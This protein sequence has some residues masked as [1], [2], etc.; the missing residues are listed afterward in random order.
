[1][2]RGEVADAVELAERT[3]ANVA[4]EEGL[5][6]A[7]ALERIVERPDRALALA[8][9][10]EKAGAPAGRVA[11]LKAEALVAKKDRAGAV[12]LLIGVGAQAP[13]HV[14]ARLRA[15][16]LLREDGKLAECER[17]LDDTVASAG[18]P[19]K[20][21]GHAQAIVIARTL[22]DE[23]RGD[24]VRAV[25]RL[26]EALTHDP[27]DARLLLARSAIDERRGEWRRAL[28]TAE[29]L[30][31]REPRNVEALNFA[32]FVAADHGND[33]PLA[34]RRL[35]ASVVLSPGSGGIIDSLG[36]V[37]FRAGD[38]ERAAAFLEQ[39]NRLEPGDAEI[40]SHLG[41]LYA[42]RGERTRA[43][44]AYRRALGLKPSDKLARELGDRVRTLDAK[45]AAG[46]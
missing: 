24:A 5:V 38:L 12:K 16:E 8:A 33:L 34:T 11:I 41:D 40:L 43:L 26:D 27:N 25:R 7:S 30:L 35:Q 44:E 18:D 23:K 14:E 42:K 15:A 3:T 13:E 32:G 1:V 6:L 31:A 46:R 19:D 4:D 10:A 20:Q 28:Q 22:V 36:W 45:S 9:R 37:Y 17:V 39:A 2:Q 21:D 29:K